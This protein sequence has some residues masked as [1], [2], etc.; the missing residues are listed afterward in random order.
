[1][2]NKE[3]TFQEKILEGVCEA[4]RVEVDRLIESHSKQILQEV[5]EIKTRIITQT[6]INIHNYVRVKDLGNTLV[7]EIVKTDKN[8]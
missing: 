2:K 8:L 5:E 4:L 3:L 6:V 7:I 1:M